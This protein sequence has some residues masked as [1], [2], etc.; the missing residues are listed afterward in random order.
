M[1]LLTG[2]AVISCEGTTDEDGDTPSGGTRSNSAAMGKWTPNRTYDTCTAAF[3]DTYFVIGPDGK[4]YPTWH[5]PTATDPDDRVCSFGHEHGRDPRGSAL[6]DS[7]RNH[8]AYDADGNGSIDT[9]ERDASG[10]PFGYAAEQLIAYNAANGFANA[11]RDEDHYGYKIAWE[12]GIARTRTVNGQI[13]TFDMACDA[14]SVLHQESY[15]AE[16]YASNLH[17]ALYAVDCSRGADAERFGGKV[18]VSAMMTFGD[19]G[20]FT[21]VQGDSF[22][23][24][25]FGTPQPPVSPAGGIER[26]RVIPTADGVFTAIMVPVGQT[27]DFTL[28]LAEDWSTTLSLR[29][30]DGTEIAYIDPSYA[31]SSPSRYFDVTQLNAIA[32]TIDLCY[33]GLSATGQLIDDP[34]RASEIVRR[35]R[36][37]ECSAIAPNGPLTLRINR[38]AYDD[39]RSVFNGCRRRVTL[40]ATRISNGGGSTVWF[41]DP[42]GGAA[43]SASFSGGIKQYIGVINNSS[44]GNAD[45]VAFG[46]DLDPCL[47]GS[48]IHAPN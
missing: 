9:V 48:N 25:R 37:P 38:I 11:N 4:K 7:I 47:P 12:N 46:A 44:A 3:H 13:Q 21:V 28:G 33:I 26:G 23:D 32:R 2:S 31:V 30:T 45:R 42:Y 41:S 34:L 10:V 16:S 36:G 17:E 19:P 5:P 18:I 22:A 6:W 27:S 40:G 35:A 1:F 15:S 29:R 43:R 24:I 8:F 20:E 39:P 14:L